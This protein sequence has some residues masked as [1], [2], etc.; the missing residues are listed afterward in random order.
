MKLSRLATA[1]A[2]LLSIA[3]SALAQ[4]P[5]PVRV[6]ELDDRPVVDPGGAKVADVYDVV[7]D[8]EEARAAYIVLSVGMKVIPVAMP[9][10]EIAFGKDKVELAFNRARLEGM[11]ALD[12]ASLGPRYKRGRD[13]IGAQFKDTN[14]ALLGEVKDLMIDLTNGGVAAVVVAFDP[15]VRQEQ[16]WV[17]IPRESLRYEPGGYVATFKLEDMRPAA[18]A[19][20]EQKRYDEARALATT[21]NRDDR[22]T[23]IKGRKFNDAQGKPVGE[24]ADIAYDASL[25]AYAIVAMA[26]GGQAAI[27]LPAQG[28]ARDGNTYTVPPTAFSPPPAGA[29]RVSEM[30]GKALIDPRDKEVGRVRDVVVNLGTGKVRYAVAQFE[31]AWIAAGYLVPIKLP[32]EDRKIELNALTGSMIFEAARWPDINNPQFISNMDAYLARQK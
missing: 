16:G 7:I 9:S 1:S 13:F 21:V 10:P 29:K 3:L 25:K 19:A 8:T 20:A 23:E 18:Q 5:A 30:I 26:A 31:P 28:L 24:L 4:A 22:F 32:A 6:G 12:M 11:P 17:A 14:G 27:A 2:L 15:K